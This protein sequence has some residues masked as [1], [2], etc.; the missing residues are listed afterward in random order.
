MKKILVLILTIGCNYLAFCQMIDGKLDKKIIVQFLKENG[1]IVDEIN[2]NDYYYE[3]IYSRK[4]LDIP[5]KRYTYY[6]IGLSSDHNRKYII[7]LKEKELIFFPTKNFDNEIK[8]I[9]YYL[10]N[11]QININTDKLI[12]FIEELKDVYDYNNNKALK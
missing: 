12:I 5:N 11:K 9:F 10:K 7:L 3:Y 6:V 2:K 4:M 1:E 8:K